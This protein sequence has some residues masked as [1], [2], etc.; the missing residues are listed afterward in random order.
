MYC[1]QCS[2]RSKFH[3]W[4]STLNVLLHPL[5]A[6][7][8]NRIT[9]HSIECCLCVVVFNKYMPL[10][11]SNDIISQNHI[12][13]SFLKEWSLHFAC[14]NQSFQFLKKIWSH[15]II[16]NRFCAVFKEC[17]ILNSA[18]PVPL[19]VRLLF[20]YNGRKLSLICN[21]SFSISIGLHWVS[22]NLALYLLLK[23]KLLL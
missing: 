4:E 1:I 21:D 2:T 9:T 17:N 11:I 20:R 19:S 5:L 22:K 3:C 12:T 18:L 10:C 7:Q 8:T 16:E 6:L 14:S 23:M 13:L 15:I